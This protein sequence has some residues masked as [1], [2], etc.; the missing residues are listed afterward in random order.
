M[1]EPIFLF[2]YDQRRLE[3]VGKGVKMRLA[4]PLNWCESGAQSVLSHRYLG[5]QEFLAPASPRRT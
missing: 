4:G 5:G 3:R 1:D 2:S